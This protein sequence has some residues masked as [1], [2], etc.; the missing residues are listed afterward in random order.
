MSNANQNVPELASV[1]AIVAPTPVLIPSKY[2]AATL[3]V[4]L[5]V[6]F[7]L[8]GVIGGGLTQVE[9][10]NLAALAAG[11]IVT[12]W[13]PLLASNWAAFLKV[14]GA[15]LAAVAIAI[16]SVIDVANGGPGWNAETTVAVV[17]AGLNALAAAVGVNRRVDEVTTAVKDPGIDNATLTA[18]DP[19]G[20]QVAVQEHGR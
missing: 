11:V 9:G 15:V 13:A 7:A 8:Q 19:K 1:E 14:G 4:I 3:G 6:V 17:F 12:Y 18:I 5:T 10:W 20:V 16:V 2:Q